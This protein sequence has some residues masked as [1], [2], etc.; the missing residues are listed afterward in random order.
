MTCCTYA[1]EV[2]DDAQFFEYFEQQLKS[3]TF[4]Q[5][6]PCEHISRYQD[7][8]ESYEVMCDGSARNQTCFSLILTSDKEFDKSVF[9]CNENMQQIVSTNGDVE[10]Y[11]KE[12]FQ[13]NKGNYVRLFFENA[14]ELIGYRAD[15]KILSYKKAKMTLG[16]LS[17]R[18][19]K[20]DIIN[21]FG[22]IIFKD[23]NYTE[24]FI[25]SVSPNVAATMQV[26]R[27]RMGSSNITRFLDYK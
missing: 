15:F 3:K 8:L 26:L 18:S 16:H 12:E 4:S 22:E 1:S 19:R 6:H 27:F 7:R 20:I 5:L 21:V 13:H 10:Y 14:E 24:K 23:F 2:S 11:S 17:G 9:D 25:L